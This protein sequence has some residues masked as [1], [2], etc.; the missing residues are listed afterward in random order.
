MYYIPCAT[1]HTRST[2]EQSMLYQAL[3]DADD[4]YDVEAPACESRTA[5]LSYDY[6]IDCTVQRMVY[7]MQYLTTCAHYVRCDM[8]HVLYDLHVIP[9]V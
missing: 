9:H 2:S 7:S 5:L 1:Y 6:M 4:D 3:A 8:C